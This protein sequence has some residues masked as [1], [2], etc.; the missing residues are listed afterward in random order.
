MVD[1]REEAGDTSATL[2]FVQVS[3]GKTE[4]NNAA[5]GILLHGGNLVKEILL[6][7]D[8]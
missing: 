2:F 3:L 8:Q 7:P 1:E 6:S 5:L 4:R